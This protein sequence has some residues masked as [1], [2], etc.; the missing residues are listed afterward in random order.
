MIENRR[1]LLTNM[2]MGLILGPF[3]GFIAFSSIVYIQI[4]N[5]SER[6][7]GLLFG[8]NALMSMAGAFTCTRVIRYFSDSVLLSVC[9]VG[10][11]WPVGHSDSGPLALPGLRRLYVRDHVLLRNEPSVKQPSDPATGRLRH[12]FGFVVHRILPV[13]VGAV[14]MR[15]VTTDWSDPSSCSA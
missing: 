7:F 10:V 8:V 15:I 5:L 9:L 11:R 2:A 6:A 14:C 13:H 12:R 1:Y 4:F 3:Y